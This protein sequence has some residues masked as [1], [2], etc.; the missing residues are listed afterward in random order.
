[1]AK[2]IG[3]FSSRPRQ[4]QR[5]RIEEVIR[6]TIICRSCQMRRLRTGTALLRGGGSGHS[7]GVFEQRFLLK[8]NLLLFC[9]QEEVTLLS[10]GA[11]SR[12]AA[13]DISSILRQWHLSQGVPVGQ[14]RKAQ[15]RGSVQH[16]VVLTALHGWSLG[17]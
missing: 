4:T 11:M 6:V 2:T 12:V 3:K 16:H 9:S 1:M 17:A 10:P 8:M 5:W 14:Y 7:L 15:G 13:D